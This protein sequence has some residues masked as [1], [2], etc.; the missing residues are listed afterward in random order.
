[1]ILGHSGVLGVLAVHP[2]W[3]LEFGLWNLPAALCLLLPVSPRA[4]IAETGSARFSWIFVYY[5]QHPP[6]LPVH[7]PVPDDDGSFLV[8]AFHARRPSQRKAS[9]L[10]WAWRRIAGRM[11]QHSTRTRARRRF[12]W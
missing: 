12:V 7:T 8:A 4:A 6:R 11:P 9:L 1:E 3:N 5:F 10:E 2:F